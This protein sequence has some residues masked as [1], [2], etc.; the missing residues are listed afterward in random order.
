[1]NNIFYVYANHD[2]GPDSRTE[3]FLNLPAPPC[4]LLDALDKLRLGEGECETFWVKE[5]YRFNFLAPYL[6]EKCDLYVLN[7]LAQ[8]LSKLN[9]E[10]CAALEG[11]LKIEAEIKK[12]APCNIP[13]LLD[14]VYNTDCCHVVGEALNDSQLGRFCAE[15]GFRPELDNLP[16]DVFNLLDF[17]RIGREHR[18]AEGGVFIERTADH[19]GGYVEQHSEWT[20]V[21]KTLDLSPKAPDYA[22][23]L[24]VSHN[25]SAA[26]LK[27]PAG[28]AEIADIPRMLDE[29]DW[30]DLTRRCLDCRVPALAEIISSSDEDIDFLNHLAKRLADMEPKTLT[31]YKALLEAAGFHSL[32]YAGLLIDTLDQY[33]FSPQVISPMDAAKEELAAILRERDAAQ[34]APHLDLYQYG[35]S[36]IQDC[37]GVLTDY[38]LIERK[39]GEPIRTM[40]NQPQQCGMEMRPYGQF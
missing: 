3:A 27:L 30:L 10:Q 31:A 34:I 12:E 36:L 9:D 24:E 23:F 17:E 8:R 39:D 25:G 14:I 19:P 5:Y 22:I 38:G 37:G 11:L 20:E 15:N 35:Q 28:E 2:I 6:G 4:E 29:P 40:K 1:M 21:Y 18:Q 32:Q 13:E 26:T 16:D 7:A 33:I